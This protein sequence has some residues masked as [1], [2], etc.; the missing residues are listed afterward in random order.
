[1]SLFLR[2]IDQSVIRK[3]IE[4]LNGVYIGNIRELLDWFY[5]GQLN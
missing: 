1:M 2:P 5:E 4:Q 3:G